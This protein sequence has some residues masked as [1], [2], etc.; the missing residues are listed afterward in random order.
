[1]RPGIFTTKVSLDVYEKENPQDLGTQVRHGRYLKIKTGLPLGIRHQELL[2]VQL[3]EDGYQ[4]Y[5][6]FG[7]Y[8][9][10]VLIPGTFRPNRV[11]NRTE[12]LK[13]IP[14]VLAFAFEAMQ[15]PNRYLWGGTLGPNFDCSGLVQTAFASQGIWL[16]R[17]AAQQCEAP[18]TRPVED[19]K[20]EPG[21]LLFFSRSNEID[22]VG[23]HLGDGF[24]IH[25]SGAT[26]GRDGIGIDHNSKNARGT[27]ANYFPIYRYS[28]R[29]CSSFA[30]K[31]D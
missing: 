29:V 31:I 10:D 25:S 18:C 28:R 26:L 6:E 15:R 1:M 27:A 7:E 30:P 5:L 11:L 8:L 9:E 2:E 17:D 4:G 12:I 20:V 13:A 16:P 21:D 24:Y 23:I 3:C 22:H 14:D 19:G